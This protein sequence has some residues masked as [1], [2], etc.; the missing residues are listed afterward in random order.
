ML[1]DSTVLLYP[2]VFDLCGRILAGPIFLDF[3]ALYYNCSLPM[4][5]AVAMDEVF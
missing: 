1:L 3:P 5:L 4:V 2:R